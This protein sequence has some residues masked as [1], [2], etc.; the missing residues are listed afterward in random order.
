MDWW[1]EHVL[2]W[3]W[4]RF[5]IGNKD[6]YIYLQ[7]SSALDE[8]VHDIHRYPIWKL[9]AGV[10]ITYVGNYLEILEMTR[11]T[12]CLFPYRAFSGLIKK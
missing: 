2:H 8:F 5:D 6:I 12:S 1:Q 7:D 4:M 10:F 3:Y 9:I 11:R